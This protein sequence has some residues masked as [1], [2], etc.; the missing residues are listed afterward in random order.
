MSLWRGKDPLIL[1]SQSRAR[2]TLLANA[3]ID[4]EAIPADID[5][6]AVQQGSGLSAPVDIAALLAGEKALA[7][8]VRLPGRFVVGADQTLALGEQ[9]FSKPAGRAQAVEQLRALAGRSHDLHSAV[10]VAR[11]G[12]ILFSDVSAAQMT[13]R[14]LTGADI[15]AYLD[16]AGEAVTSSVGAY[17]LEG[18]GVHLFERIEG[19]HFTILG[20]PLLPLLAFLRGERLLRL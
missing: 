11:N 6:R 17:Q 1:A 10:A 2:Q 13:M 14:Q 8:S 4:F 5:E 19:D 3:G 7:V 12:K 16:H 15:R 9:L 20:L 18:L